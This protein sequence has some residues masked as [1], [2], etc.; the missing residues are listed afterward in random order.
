M[1]FGPT[2]VADA[3]DCI[4]AHSVRVAG[5]VFKKGRRLSAVDTVALAEAGIV[6]VLAA[7]FEAD[8]VPEDAAA[9]A[10]A[11]AAGGAHT[12]TSAAFTGRCNLYAEGAGVVLIDR[13]R[14]DRL[15]QVD[16]AITIATLPPFDLVTA[17]QLL[18]TIK[19][20]PFAA[21]RAAV[22][23]CIA[24]ARSETPPVRVAP[25]RPHSVGLVMT[26][27][28]GTKESVLDKTA[29]VLRDRLD[30]LGSTLVAEQRCDHDEGALAGAVKALLDR[31]CAPILVYGASAIVDRR[32][33]VPAGIVAAGG[34]IDHFGMPVDPGNLILTAHVGDIPVIGLPGCARSPKLNGVDWVLWRLL[35]GVPVDSGAIQAMGVGGLLKEIPSRPQLREPSAG[36]GAPRVPRIT[37]VVLAAGQSRRMGAANKLLEAVHGEA[38]VRRV[39][40]HAQASQA[41]DVVVVLGHQGERVRA[42][43]ADTGVSFTDSPHFADGLSASLK[44]GIAAVPSASDGA[45]VLL[46]DMPGVTADHIDRLIAGFNPVEG[47]G[48]C[49]PTTRGKRGNPVLW[50]RAFFD[51]I[52]S[53]SGDVGARHLIGTHQ[54]AVCEVA[55]E[56]DAIFVDVDTPAALQAYRDRTENA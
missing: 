15:N 13:E 56:D 33:V 2:P 3:E 34:A 51:E 24:I 44:A 55:L 6:S 53:L 25:I 1:I 37:A 35:A 43:L 49:V 32:D 8:D 4:L 17:G 46:G 14:I 23:E 27:L 31:G 50:G 40:A 54:D 48:I 7:R 45:V 42:A 38:M 28:P 12:K 36:D 26:V 29:G 22:D 19:I 10:V 9:A 30:Q 20:I 11:E 21:A 41:A 47:R 39:V 5:T 52:A 18:A 16:E